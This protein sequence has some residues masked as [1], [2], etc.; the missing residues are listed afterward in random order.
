MKYESYSMVSAGCTAV[1]GAAP[2]PSLT[3]MP[4]GLVGGATVVGD[5]VDSSDWT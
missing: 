2:P 3:G 4:S 5:I 1:T